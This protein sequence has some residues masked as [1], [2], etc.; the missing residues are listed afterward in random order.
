VKYAWI[1]QQQATFRVS[2]LG[3]MLEVSRSGYYEWLSRP[4]SSARADADHQ[5]Q[6]KVQH[7]CA[8]GRGTYGT[9]RIKY[10]LAQEGL[11]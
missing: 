8:Q 9:R 1:Q 11:W 10:L 6:T 4:P 2:S 5:V 7:Y 3:R